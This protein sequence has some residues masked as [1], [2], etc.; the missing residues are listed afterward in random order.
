MWLFLYLQP[1]LQV[2]R[3]KSVDKRIDT[4]GCSAGPGAAETQRRALGRVVGPAFPLTDRWLRYR[5]SQAAADWVACISRDRCIIIFRGRTVGLD[6]GSAS[7]PILGRNLSKKHAKFGVPTRNGGDLSTLESGSRCKSG[8]DL[9][10]VA[11]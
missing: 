11:D 4:A 1:I 3:V 8:T 9:V 2:A 7:V 6:S 5:V 10:E